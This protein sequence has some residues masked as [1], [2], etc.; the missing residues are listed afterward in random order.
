MSVIPNNN[1][2]VAQLIDANLDRARE[3]LRVI[4]DWC[5]FVLKNKS[6]VIQIKNWRQQ[7]GA[8][9][10]DIYKDARSVS[11]DQGTGLGHP[12]QNKRL[13]ASQIVAANFARVQEALRVLEEFARPNHQELST[14]ASKIRYEIYQLELI[15]LKASNQNQRLQKLIACKLCLITKPH[16]EL[17][18]T[19][20]SALKAGVTMVQFRL[21]EG[22]DLAFIEQAKELSYICKQY[23]SLFIINDRIDIA[24]ASEAD[25][26]HLGQNDLPIEIARK[27][28][29]SEKI[30]GLSTHSLE[31]A[32][33]AANKNCD[34][35]GIGPIFKTNSKPS[36][37]FIGTEVLK[38]LSIQIKIPWFA[39]G[40]INKSN[41]SEVIESGANRIAVI[42]AI[43]NSQDPYGACKELL[44]TFQ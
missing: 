29:G 39:I 20:E 32:K 6:L 30:I 44:E 2:N 11:S 34:Y 12:N 19:V 36:K 23:K 35:L 9:H 1:Q 38:K 16:K 5:R 15:V 28:I 25:G 31:E 43:M 26:V 40:G 8:N 37:D 3:G 18:K 27:V 42:N 4:E 7:L 33:I 17:I 14:L 41:A 22:S 24:I 10:L 13:E 21:K